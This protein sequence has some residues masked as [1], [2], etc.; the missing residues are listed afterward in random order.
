M[1]AGL[2]G[3]YPTAVEPAQLA[4]Q[5]SAQAGKWGNL[6]DD[7]EV[8]RAR[9]T[10]A[11]RS[12][13]AADLAL[14]TARLRLGYAAAAAA[15]LRPYLPQMRADPRANAGLIQTYAQAQVDAGDA[16]AAE[17]VLRPLLAEAK[18]SRPFRQL[19]VAA[20]AR[21]GDRAAASAM[22][23]DIAPLPDDA[24]LGERMALAV[25]WQPVGGADAA[26]ALDALSDRMAGPEGETASA[27]A[28]EQFGML[29][30]PTDRD[31]IAA[32]RRALKLDSKRPVS[33]NN[34]AMRLLKRGASADQAEALQLA[35]SAA[36]A[37]A[38][39]DAPTRASLLDTLA[40]AQS[41]AGQTDAA[42]LTLDHATRLDPRN[43]Q[44]WV[45][46][47]EAQL[48]QDRPADAKATL[49]TAGRL[50][51]RDGLADPSLA[52]RLAAARAAVKAKGQ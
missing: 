52:P 5:A 26:A 37:A 48:A 45:H 22:L 40:E 36:D 21:R 11:G 16:A 23:R 2:R 27:A 47:A 43:L 46:L 17:E 12:T 30:E 39:L 50:I 41:A 15:Q 20:A 4:A 35:Q 29:L 1:A 28:W 51:D 24:T 3:R 10:D 42:A 44:W 32:Y 9:L 18:S 6:A 14:A 31:P 8:W 25:A 49:Q 7:A 33:A 19:W 13:E 38:S 34:L